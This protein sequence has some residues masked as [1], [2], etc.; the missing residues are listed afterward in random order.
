MIYFDNS[1]TSRNKPKEVYDAFNYYVRDIGVSPGRGSYALGITAS[2]ML[3]QSR[4]AVAKFFG[5][6]NSNNVVFTKNSTEAI[7]L[8]FNG[9]LN[10][11]DRIS[12][13]LIEL[14]SQDIN[15]QRIF[16]TI[17]RAGIKLSSADIIKNNLFK[18]C[19]DVCNNAHKTREEV[20]NLHDSLWEAIFYK[21]EST[22]NLWDEKRIFGNVQKSNLEFLLYCVAEI[23]WGRNDELFSKL[24]K[25]YVDNT[26]NY[27]YEQ[28]GDL[29][30]EISKYGCRFV[31]NFI[32]VVRNSI[33]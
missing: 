8:F 11:G 3:Y 30:Q 32:K 2:R 1:A 21:D 10:S 12:I 4:K 16:D 15:E 5:I 24:E 31:I 20:C 13:V 19:L 22:S 23:K 33:I 18:K 7:N 28:M 9:Y 17:N 27:N 26:A 25:V 14:T 6:D 29:I